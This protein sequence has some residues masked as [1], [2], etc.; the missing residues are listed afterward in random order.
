MIAVHRPDEI[1]TSPANRDL[2]DRCR[3]SRSTSSR[4]QRTGANYFYKRHLL[5]SNI[6]EQGM[7]YSVEY[8]IP[9]DVV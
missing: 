3:E 4:S 5:K 7:P 6:A 2:C 8:I 1:C 9:S